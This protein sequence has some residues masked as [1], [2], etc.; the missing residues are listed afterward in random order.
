MGLKIEI[1]TYYLRAGSPFNFLFSPSFVSL[2]PC[3]HVKLA[4]SFKQP[5]CLIAHM[6][7]SLLQLLWIH[8]SFCRMKDSDFDKPFSFL[9]F[10]ALFGITPAV[11]VD[12]GPQNLQSCIWTP[13]L[14]LGPAHIISLGRSVWRRSSG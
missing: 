14:K 5:S 12:V 3:V 11:Y 8:S 2:N 4:R 1:Y 7:I 9:F 10:A 13:T 6:S